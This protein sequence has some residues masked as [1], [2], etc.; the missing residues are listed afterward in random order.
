[1]ERLGLWGDGTAFKSFDSF[2][3]SITKRGL[4]KWHSFQ[5]RLR[6]VSL[7]SKSVEENARD[8]QM[9]TRNA[10]SRAYT[11]LTKLK[12][13]REAARCLFSAPMIHIQI[14]PTDPPTFP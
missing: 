14:L 8:T 5:P 13:E 1:M 2:L 12:K 3:A 10:L 11:P 6:A 4:G 7:F 9:T